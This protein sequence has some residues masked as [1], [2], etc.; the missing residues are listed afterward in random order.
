MEATAPWIKPCSTGET[1]MLFLP[2]NKARAKAF[3]CR[4]KHACKG[5]LV[6][7]LTVAV[8][9]STADCE[10]LALTCAFP[11]FLGVAIAFFLLHWFKTF[12]HVQI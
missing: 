8:T 12:G 10:S 3:G 1:S 6:L 4:A 11:H 9:R 2:G 7:S 5:A